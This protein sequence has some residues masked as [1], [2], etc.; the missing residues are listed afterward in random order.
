[1]KLPCYLLLL[2]L[3]LAAFGQNTT[4]KTT[5]KTTTSDPLPPMNTGPVAVETPLPASIKV[6]SIGSLPKQRD[7]SIAAGT[8]VYI[9]L[10]QIQYT[11]DENGVLSRLP[12]PRG[13]SAS[14]KIKTVVSPKE[15]IIENQDVVL[16]SAKKE[17]VGAYASFL[18]ALDG[19]NDL[20]GAD[21]LIHY[22]EVPNCP[23]PTSDQV[24]A[25]L[26]SGQDLKVVQA[27]ADRGGKDTAFTLKW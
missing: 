18:V 15:V 22:H 24:L 12:Y 7:G 21:G 23:I 17:T 13:K 9:S 3:P 19:P 26:K 27:S 6:I 1:M 10:A 20:P 4:S 8:S 5:G 16:I 2:A 14:G 11:V 25:A